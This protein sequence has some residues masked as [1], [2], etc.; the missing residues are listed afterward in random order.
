MDIDHLKRRVDNDIFS[1]RD[2][3][4]MAGV[5]AASIA[6]LELPFTVWARTK[7]ASAT[8]PEHGVSVHP[9]PLSQVS[10]LAGPFKDNM[11]RTLNYLSFVDPDR[12]LYTFR[13]NVGLPTNGAVKCGGWEDR[14]VSCVGTAWDICYLP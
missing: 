3:L 6:A 2:I 5:T 9:F 11:K 13:A 8:L 10:L 14:V 12:L 4:Q 7:R 1:R